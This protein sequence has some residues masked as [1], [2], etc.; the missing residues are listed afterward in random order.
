MGD[1]TDKLARQTHVFLEA[2][3]D[4]ADRD[5]VQH[6]WMVLLFHCCNFSLLCC[7]A[8]CQMILQNDTDMQDL[9]METLWVLANKMEKYYNQTGATYGEGKSKTPL[10]VSDT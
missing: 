6:L 7:Q 3:L 5:L 8:D 10:S 4:C 1:M 9:L 2:M